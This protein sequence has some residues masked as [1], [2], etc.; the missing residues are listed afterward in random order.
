MIPEA[1]YRDVCGLIIRLAFTNLGTGETAA[2]HGGTPS[3]QLLQI[4]KRIARF[5]EIIEEIAEL[6]YDAQKMITHGGRLNGTFKST[7]TN[8]V[9]V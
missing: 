3:E 1:S 4:T 5:E 8:T 6:Q 9:T 2:Y 7:K